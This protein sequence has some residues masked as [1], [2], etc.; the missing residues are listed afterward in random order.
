MRDLVEALATAGVTAAFAG[1]A[2]SRQKEFVRQVVTA[3]A[4]ATRERRLAK[5]VAS[6]SA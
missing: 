1:L 2:P 6:L 3:K 5:I 4:P